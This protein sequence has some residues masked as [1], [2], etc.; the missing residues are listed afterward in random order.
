MPSFDLCF[1]QS[2]QSLKLR[3]H[4]QELFVARDIEV[5]RIVHAAL[6]PT[7]LAML[8]GL[9]VTSDSVTDDAAIEIGR[10]DAPVLVWRAATLGRFHLTLQLLD[11]SS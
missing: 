1:A 6:L 2:L 5:Q 11:L 7:F 9:Y 10:T 3:L 4:L 8:Q